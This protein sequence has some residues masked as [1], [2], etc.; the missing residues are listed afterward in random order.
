KNRLVP[1]L[2][3][4]LVC[5]WV[6]CAPAPVEP[7]SPQSPRVSPCGS[8]ASQQFAEPPDIDASTLPID[9][10]GQ[11]ELIL[12]VHRD[13]ARF[14]YR[15]RWNGTIQ[16]LAPTIRVRP[17]ERF[18]IRIVN[19]ISAPSKG[20]TVASNVLPRCMPMSMPLV[21]AV[22]YV[23]YL[24]REIDDRWM[25]KLST[26]TNLHL[27]G[28]EGPADEENVFLSTLSTP[29]HACEYSIVV[30]K[31]QPPGTYFYHPHV[32]GG[33]FAQVAGGLSGVWIVE[34]D[35]PQ[36]ARADEHVLVLRYVSPNGVDNAF[37]PDDSA[38]YGAGA[39]HASAKKSAAPVAY[40]PFD[41]PAWPLSLPMRANGFSLDTHGCDGI[42]P[43]A[44]VGVNG[45]VGPASLNVPAGATQLLRIVN[46]TSDSP[47]MLKLRDSG[48]KTVPMHVVELDGIPVGGD[49]ARPLSQFVA[50]DRLMLTPASRAAILVTAAA[51]QGLTLT[52]THYCEGSYAFFQMRHELLNVVGTIDPSG[53]APANV[54][55][56]PI[57]EANT[58]ATKLVE[59][60]RTHRASVRRRAITF[61]EYLFAPKGKI[62]EH[63]SYFI[64]DTTH[65]NFH[66]HAYYPAYAKG[67]SVPSAADI[68]VKR[69][70][71]EEWYLFNTTM[72]SHTFHV[73]Q[74]TFV[75]ERG[76]GG[77]PAT[78]DT[79]FVPVGKLLPD[80]AD[81]DYP[82][83]K[84]SVTKLLLDFRNVPHGTFVFHCHMLFHEDRGMMGVIRVV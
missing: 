20:E 3:L 27:H 79:T 41:P 13:G 65:P 21:P 56:V 14:C 72:E 16:T 48:G 58:P 80:R 42:L 34:P 4:A 33:S 18:A 76:P 23:G 70:T 82:L 11:R 7:A 29:M 5:G 69:G 71:V 12:A 49:T 40:D 61:T 51:G 64:T 84:P 73:H 57:D 74:M 25:P 59:Y 15:Y 60:A 75:A 1:F 66:E 10:N 63:S 22:H 31:T 43:E 8:P 19:D 26:D 68:V 47:K 54:A 17:G 2:G 81:P 83:V 32:H 35:A 50:V 46:A 44:I 39:G 9:A 36:I 24:N 37:V 30:P 53:S 67:G 62:P 28:F 6:L 45:S 38:L 78:V 77:A 52:S 55:S